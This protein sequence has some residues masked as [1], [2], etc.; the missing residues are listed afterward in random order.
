MRKKTRKSFGMK[1]REHLLD[2]LENK[3]K[4]DLALGKYKNP[5]EYYDV[6]KKIDEL[7]AESELE[8]RRTRKFPIILSRDKGRT[9]KLM[10]KDL[11]ELHEKL[12]QELG[13][14]FIG[15]VVSGSRAGGYAHPESDVDY[16]IIT[17]KRLPEKKASGVRRLSDHF[18]KEKNQEGGGSFASHGPAIISSE[19]LHA[20]VKEQ[21]VGE[22]L[23]EL[24]AGYSPLENPALE[25]LK[26]ELVQEIAK[27]KNP[28]KYWDK[29]IREYAKEFFE[30]PEAITRAVT[31]RAEA[32]GLTVEEYKKLRKDR[33]KL[34]PDW[35]QVKKKY[36]V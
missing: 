28:K 32:A 26:K 22:E 13:P 19:E 6:R 3:A 31:K 16:I 2:L 29:G 15:I 10:L 8:I 25:K 30:P 5:E 11:P 7:R 33:L 14:D 17:K 1:V 36:G 35:K 4:K 23:S 20:Q 24:F 9:I 27:T 12:K 34:I 18:L 21:V